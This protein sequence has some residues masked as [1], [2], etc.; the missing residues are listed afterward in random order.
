MKLCIS[1]L[2]CTQHKQ[3]RVENVGLGHHTFRPT[4]F[5][6]YISSNI[7]AP[8]FFYDR[9]FNNLFQID[10]YVYRTMLSDRPTELIFSSTTFL[11]WPL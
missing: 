8:P 9:V 5:Y 10:A 4:F 3:T 6:D 11:V 2:S 1:F 7:T